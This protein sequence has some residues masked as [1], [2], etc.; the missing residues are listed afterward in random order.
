MSTVKI[1]IRK[2]AFTFEGKEKDCLE[3]AAE[4]AVKHNMDRAPEPDS[5]KYLPNNNIQY[6]WTYTIPDSS[7]VDIQCI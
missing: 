6:T 7:T 1:K 3:K 4:I 5:V 2:I